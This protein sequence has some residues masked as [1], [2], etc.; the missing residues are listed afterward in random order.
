MFLLLPL[1]TITTLTRITVLPYS[2]PRNQHAVMGIIKAS[3]ADSWI[4]IHFTVNG[5]PF[6]GLGQVSEGSLASATG[7]L[8]GRR[9][10]RRDWRG[11]ISKGSLTYMPRRVA[12]RHL[13]PRHW[14]GAVSEGSITYLTRTVAGRHPAPRPWPGRI[15]EGSRTYLNMPMAVRHLAPGARPRQV[16]GGFP[17]YLTE[18][19]AGSQVACTGWPGQNGEVLRGR[20]EAVVG[21]VVQG[22]H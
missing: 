8:T 5:V 19:V 3:K 20:W 10:P 22:R 2:N 7:L 16:S 14:P 6:R 12:V 13:A 18:R 15:S 17:T 1:L 21:S 9:L 4:F 11:Q